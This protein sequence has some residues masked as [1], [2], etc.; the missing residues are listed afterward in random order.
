MRDD[1]ERPLDERG[2]AQAR[3]LIELLADVRVA[4]I[5]TSP[6]RR[7]VQTVE[8]LAAALNIEIELRDE[9]GEERQFAEG[10]ELVHALAR[11]DAVVCGHGGLETAVP[12]PP[13]WKKGAAF[14]VGDDGQVFE[15]RRA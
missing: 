14:L 1:R 2:L 5:I 15:V 3:G 11:A 4:R 10:I 7:C 12:H 9:L 8:P 6:Y 13:R